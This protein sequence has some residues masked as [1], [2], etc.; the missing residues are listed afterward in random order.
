MKTSAMMESAGEVP[1]LQSDEDAKRP[2]MS[3][4]RSPALTGQSFQRPDPTSVFERHYS[5][6]ELASL[7]NLSDRTIR[8]IFI[9][10][11]GVLE[12][13]ACERMRKRAYKTLRI[14]ESVARRVHRKLKRAG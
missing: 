2:P 8:R 7:W 11:P 9:G 10:E 3:L 6:K 13:G 5:V 14:P 12:W 1:R 4:G